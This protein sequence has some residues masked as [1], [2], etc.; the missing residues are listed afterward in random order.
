MVQVDVAGPGLPQTFDFIPDDVRL[1]ANTVMSECVIQ[2]NKIGGFATSDL[3]AMNDWITAGDT[4]LNG[5]Y[6]T[7]HPIFHSSL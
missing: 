4:S 7:S 5:P 6:R 2:S 1:M 3:H